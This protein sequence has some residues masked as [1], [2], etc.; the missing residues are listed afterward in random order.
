VTSTQ[1]V[2]S[3]I[4]QISTQI[5][6]SIQTILASYTSTQTISE[7]LTLTLTELRDCTY[8][9]TSVATE[10]ITFTPAPVTKTIPGPYAT[11][12]PLNNTFPIPVDNTNGTK[13]SYCECTRSVLTGLYCGYCSQIR[14]CERGQDCWADAYSCGETCMNYG[15]MGYCTEEAASTEAKVN[16]PFY[17]V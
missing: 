8:T 16:C 4:T 10:T 6:T 13:Y 7:Y 12:S 11:P 2:Y 9:A 5:S 15:P 1:S 14:S 17:V 3:T